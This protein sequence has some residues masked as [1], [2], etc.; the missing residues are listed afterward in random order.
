MRR[1]Y[2]EIGFDGALEGFVSRPSALRDA[3]DL[4]AAVYIA[5]SDARRAYHIVCQTSVS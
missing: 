2:V 5:A 4:P 1:P 3:K